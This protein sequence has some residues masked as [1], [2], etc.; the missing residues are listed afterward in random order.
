MICENEQF[1]SAASVSIMGRGEAISS[2]WQD[3]RDERLA[4][5]HHIRYDFRNKR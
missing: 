4:S 5:I 3:R 2:S 1:I